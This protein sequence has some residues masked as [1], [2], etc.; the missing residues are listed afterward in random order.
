MSAVMK[1]DAVVA[2]ID[3]RHVSTTMLRTAAKKVEAQIEENIHKDRAAL[4]A[5]MEQKAAKAG[6]TLA[7]LFA[8]QYRNPDDHSQTWS[9]KGARPNWLKTELAA[10]RSLSEFLIDGPTGPSKDFGKVVGAQKGKKI[11]AKRRGPKP[12]TKA[13]PRRKYQN[14][15]NP[16][17]TYGGFGRYP[18]WMVAKI[19][20]GVPKESMQL[21]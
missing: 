10:G 17:E 5:E 4:K 12:G 1:D 7:E 9:G 15:D 21:R 20:A 8:T 2:S 19:A 13:H 6:F 16:S 14:P 18:P 11:K 3:W